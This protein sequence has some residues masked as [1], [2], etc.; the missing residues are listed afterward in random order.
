MQSLQ[1]EEQAKLGS[2]CMQTAYG[3][4]RLR[5][6]ATHTEDLKLG[7]HKPTT[8]EQL[9]QDRPQGEPIGTREP[10]LARLSFSGTHLPYATK[11]MTDQQPAK[12]TLCYR[13]AAP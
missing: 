6:G 9:M 13:A 7:G 12:C 1:A 5:M 10:C 4:Y 3:G 8:A 11:H 2:C